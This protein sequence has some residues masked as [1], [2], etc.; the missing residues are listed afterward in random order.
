M[1]TIKTTNI[2]HGSNSG[3]SNL[4][5]NDT[6][7]VEARKVN[8]CQRIVLEQFYHPC[9]GSTIATSGGNVT[10]QNVT[11]SYT[12]SSSYADLTG[13]TISYV[14]PTGTTM[15][16]YK[17]Y[18][19]HG[20]DTNHNI[21]HNKFFIDSDE[22]TYQR[23]TMSAHIHLETPVTVEIGIPIGGTANTDTGRQ[24]SWSSAKTLKLT[25]RVFAS[26]QEAKH[27]ATFYWDGAQGAHFRIPSIGITAIG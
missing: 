20:V 9:D 5:L 8:G 4:V 25:S 19:H 15:V 13:S 24:A 2:T 17:F 18:Y 10:L 11:S 12:L 3:T 27:H 6:G 22:V 7:N 26:A 23:Y 16:I 1:R 21:S 14:P